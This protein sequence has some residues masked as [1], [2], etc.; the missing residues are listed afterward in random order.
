M[1][2]RVQ[3]PD[4]RWIYVPDLDPYLEQISYG[5]SPI[6][7][8]PWGMEE[9]EEEDEGTLAGSAWE[10]IKSIPS[11]VADIFLSG[12]QAAV[13]VATPFADLPVEKRL[14]QQASKRARERD[15]AYQ[16][17]FLPAVGTGLGQVAGLSALSRLPGGWYAAM[18]AGIGMGISDQTRR[19]ADYE[20]RT[21]TDVP[22]YKE[23]AAHMMGALIGLTEVIPVK[24]GIFPTSVSKMMDRM[25]SGF[26]PNS[27]RRVSQLEAKYGFRDIATTALMEATQEASANWLQSVSARGLYD[28]DAMKDLARSMAED[29]KVGG[30]VGGLVKL[31]QH[32]ILRSKIRGGSSDRNANAEVM[33]ARYRHDQIIKDVSSNI[34]GI[35]EEMSPVLSDLGIGRGLATDIIRLMGGEFSAIPTGLDHVLSSGE[36]SRFQVRGLIKEF[37][38][39]NESAKSQL[40]RLIEYHSNAGNDTEVERYIK[41]R[42][43]IDK[44]ATARINNLAKNLPGL[45]GGLGDMGG[46]TGNMQYE[47]A[48]EAAIDADAVESMMDVHEARKKQKE[49][50]KK[51]SFLTA[52]RSL[53]GGSYKLS[54]LFHMAESLGTHRGPG[55]EKVH[56]ESLADDTQTIPDIELASS[57]RSNFDI[58]SL[59]EMLFA[60]R[61][62]HEEASSDQQYVDKS[63]VMDG[64]RFGDSVR[65]TLGSTQRTDARRALYDLDVK[66]E[67]VE[68]NNDALYKKHIFTRELSEI[69]RKKKYDSDEEWTQHRDETQSYISRQSQQNNAEI[70]RINREKSIIYLRLLSDRLQSARTYFA[71]NI[72]AKQKAAQRVLGSPNTDR[73]DLWLDKTINTVIYSEHNGQR[74]KDLASEKAREFEEGLAA[75]TDVPDA[76]KEAA[77]AAFISENTR[78]FVQLPR[79]ISAT[80][81]TKIAS[82][83]VEDS[84]ESEDVLE[85]AF[86]KRALADI[87]VWR[88]DDELYDVDPY[89][90]PIVKKTR[91]VV[92]E[93]EKKLERPLTDESGKV[94]PK[95]MHKEDISVNDIEKL[96]ASKNIYLR[97]EIRIGS[98]LAKETGTGVESRPFKKLLEDMTGALSWENA[99]YGQRL[100]MYS[101][102]LQLPA[103][104]KSRSSPEER[105]YLL[106][107]G[108]IEGVFEEADYRPLFLPDFYH[109]PSIDSHINFMTDRV[110]GATIEG[111][112]EFPSL[113]IGTLKKQTQAALGDK[114]NNKAYYESLA[115]L[116]ETGAFNRTAEPAPARVST[117]DKDLL[118]EADRLEGEA[119][120]LEYGEGLI[121]SI[122]DARLWR[123]EDMTEVELLE[124]EREGYDVLRRE[125]RWLRPHPR[126]ATRGFFNIPTRLGVTLTPR[127]EEALRAEMGPDRDPNK[128]VELDEL[129]AEDQE[130]LDANRRER[131][132]AE[133]FNDEATRAE[134]LEQAQQ[135]LENL[136]EEEKLELLEG[137]GRHQ[138]KEPGDAERLG[139]Q[140]I[141]VLGNNEL[142]HLLEHVGDIPHRISPRGTWVDHRST[143]EKINKALNLLMKSYG[144]PVEVW[145]AGYE[146]PEY[147]QWVQSGSG[148]AKDLEEHLSGVGIGSDLKS[149]EVLEEAAELRRQYAEAHRQIPVY[150]QVQRL[151]T[152]APIALAEGRYG[153]AI[154]A[155]NQLR[156]ILEAEGGWDAP[157]EFSPEAEAFVPLTPEEFEVEVEKRFVES[158]ANEAARDQ[159][160]QEAQAIAD[161][162]D[163]PI[164]RSLA[165]QLV[166]PPLYPEGHTKAG[167]MKVAAWVPDWYTSRTPEAADRRRA[168]A[169]PELRKILNTGTMDPDF[170]ILGR[171][172][173]TMSPVTGNRVGESEAPRIA[174]V[175]STDAGKGG[176]SWQIIWKTK[177][178]STHPD[179]IVIARLEFHKNGKPNQV[180]Y[181]KGRVVGAR[182]PGRGGARQA[183]EVKTLVGRKHV[184][185][186]LDPITGQY[187]SGMTVTTSFKGRRGVT[188]DAEDILSGAA[189]ARE[190]PR[191][192]PIEREAAIP[193]E[194]LLRREKEKKDFAVIRTLARER[195]AARREVRGVQAHEQRVEAHNK[196]EEAKI[197][198][199][200]QRRKETER[201]PSALSKNR[202]RFNVNFEPTEPAAGELE[203]TEPGDDTR[204]R[205]EKMWIN[206]TN[207]GLVHRLLSDPRWKNQ[208]DDMLD[209]YNERRPGAQLNREEFIKQYTA[210]VTS[211]T[212][213][214]DLSDLGILETIQGAVA[215]PGGLAPTDNILDLGS[216]AGKNLVRALMKSGA[217]PSSLQ[218]NV[219]AVRRRFVDTMKT[220]FETL[221]GKVVEL[222]QA[223]RLPDNIQR[224]YVDDI[225]GLFQFM[226]EVAIRG[227]DMNADLPALYDRPGNRIIINLA[228]IDPNDM[229]SAQEVVK[230]A[231]FHEGL[232]ALIIRDHLTE[233]ELNVLYGFVRDKK[234]IVP[235]EIDEEAYNAQL[236]WFERSVVAHKDSELAEADIEKEAIISLLENL[237]QHPDLYVEGKK[238]RTITKGVRGF[239]EGFVDAA[240]DS[241][242]VDV[243]R[244]LGRIERG[245]VSERTA[246][247]LGDT[248]YT[249]DSIVR[250]ND[251][252]RYANPED[253]RKLKAAIVLRDAAPSD[254]MREIEQAKI[255][256]ISDKIVANRG[257]IRESAPPPPDAVQAIENQRQAIEHY[258]ATF[259]GEVPLLSLDQKNRDS[260]AYKLALDTFME[261]RGKDPRY[262][263]KMPEPYQKFFNKMSP[264]S[265]NLLDLVA[266][267]EKAGVVTPL[268][269]D[270]TRKSLEEGGILS[271]DYVRRPWWKGGGI[272]GDLSEADTETLKDQPTTGDNIKDTVENLKGSVDGLRYLY[273][274]RRQYIV[275]QT[276]K[277]I[278]AQ[279]RAQLDA[280]TSALVMWRN[281]DNALNWLPSLMLRGPL[282]Y[283]GTTVGSGRF[284]NAPIYDNDLQ[285]KYGGDGR[286][287]GLNDIIAPIIDAGSQQAALTYGL[288]KRVRWTRDRLE[289][290]QSATAGVDLENLNP[291]TR[292]KLKLFQESYEDIK[293]AVRKLTE[294]QMDDIVQEIET[295]ESNKIIIEFW[296]RYDAYDN[297]MIKMS[298]NTGMIT[299]EVRDEW[300][301]M[302]YAP[303]YRETMENED[304]P[305]GSQEQIAKRR[306]NV[307]EKALTESMK[308]IT[309]KLADSIITNTQALV[310]D[311]MMNTAVSRTVRDAVA[312]GEARK[313]NISAV[314]ASL[315]DRVVRVMEHGVPTYYQLDDA[316]V[317][318]SAMLLGFNPKRQLQ[319]LFGEHKLGKFMQTALTKSSSWLRDA[320][321]RTPPFA[322]KN[323]FRDSWNAMSL[324]GG[325][326][327]LILKAF[328]NAINPDSLRRADELGLSIGIDFVAEPGEYGNRM[329]SELKKANLDWKN[330]LNAFSIFWNFSGRIAKQSEVATRLAVYD[331]I[332]AMTGDKALA[333]HYAIEIMNYGRR[334][335]SPVLSTYMATVPF[336][337]GR[338]EGLDVTY[339]GLRGKKGSSDIPGVYGYGLTTGEYEGLPF[340]KKTRAKVVSRGL[341]LTAAT[342]VLYLLMRDDEEWQDLRDETRSDNWVLPLSDH[343]WIKIPIPFEIGVIFKV[344]PEKMFEAITEADV[345]VGDVGEEAWRQLRTSLSMG[346]PQLFTPVVNAMRNY[347]TFRKDGIVDSWMEDTLSPNEQRN[348]Y[349]SNVA[350]GVADLANSVPL[351]NKLDFL[352]S[353]MKVEYMMRQY[354]GT[355]GSYVVT[356]ADRIAR[357]G[358]LPDIP[359]D[360]YM[361]L[362][363]AES[364]I[365]TNKDFDW[366]S[367]I[368]GEGI[369]NV[370]LLGDLLTD[371]RTRQGSQQAFFEMIEDLDIVL[372]TLSSI[373]DR[374]YLKGFEYRKKHLDIL[375]HQR[376]L[377]FMQNQLK[378]WRERRDHF[379]KIPLESM[380]TDE[381]REYYQRLLESR[382][383]I[384]ASVND[385]MAS[386]R[387]E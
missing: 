236:T 331:R 30:A 103:H 352:T 227:E 208:I 144:M 116:I 118:D 180:T 64:F 363:E 264:L 346:G 151:A 50:S 96:L 86:E 190:Q 58:A 75:E 296:D 245:E 237:T 65:G 356:V 204:A 243:M 295:K 59:G 23:S 78:R 150:N 76:E 35:S 250:S 199:R 383:S 102:L 366:K 152:A 306:K 300:L 313:I 359:F 256:D 349:T 325:G 177:K 357:T 38:A 338:L 271:G 85:D 292:R 252:L 25:R 268:D 379:S 314:A 92:A 193:E 339:R 334:G 282:S 73:F 147:Q 80:Q 97:D 184:I 345:D 156:D 159:T 202:V 11:G 235:K 170:P 215:M 145:E 124:L 322:T 172:L 273:L 327:E 212:P 294:A 323:V 137:T 119:D 244:I 266:D 37:T 128:R 95:K 196:R 129:I 240:K 74:M 265:P 91:K 136:T 304:F 173:L 53:M 29:F 376:Q 108:T 175:I 378:Q 181:S 60:S 269:G 155:L 217:L 154:S 40:D 254:Q 93:L 146:S 342:G 90:I 305:I 120:P 270:V 101:R 226:G 7:G 83:F 191:R 77:R 17:A 123:Q 337:N 84:K 289:S 134:Q 317:A 308:P 4:G 187:R 55:S 351:V 354:L 148:F 214:Q 261:M 302:P 287:Q 348:R 48:K 24:F 68:K 377:R 249:N 279:N 89:G 303:F 206:E 8:L 125:A 158:K 70:S 276:D 182:G 28:P 161:E 69:D 107:R 198:S 33:R 81:V 162:G 219:H 183:T 262:A 110:M 328:G 307:V 329:R 72:S 372:A 233:E 140:H 39:R 127:I 201:A 362:A 54:G 126:F 298:Y 178:S 218:D 375:R 336:M 43:A 22:W 285:E 259:S 105:R 203:I 321:T 71:G 367:L 12:A 220:R 131:L 6:P 100:L 257:I 104:Y 189:E 316:Q 330:P 49:Y 320:V 61:G 194:V 42:V 47:E 373:T 15:P 186:P 280:E 368:G 82:L 263:Y 130:T 62:K 299:R 310:R 27:L 169:N 371:P 9:E 67:A 355:M 290:I 281:S 10:G 13:G 324:T 113:S 286:V 20:Q 229:V 1:P 228:A 232:H 200:E 380:S 36:I 138:R 45:E 197:L 238:T 386:I 188:R 291:E 165:G 311:A 340:W 34:T 139:Q 274:D 31:A 335:A 332:L 106:D 333:V 171:I 318:M 87:A 272:E 26:S 66:L 16:D 99:T 361:N 18:G 278:A 166:R 319:K 56:L 174:Y 381:G 51:P 94:A 195:A 79:D 277:L 326:P 192:D 98:L 301:S 374:D 239:L 258:R 3:L 358:I 176:T 353:P 297:H 88:A 57:D 111:H 288:I 141:E 230:Q 341:A 142:S 344:I 114:F 157:F 112:L 133:L 213:L 246:G 222:L 221:D 225:D 121:G 223:M 347:D 14:R 267:V 385:L 179:G 234:N 251:L 275:K 207:P 5:S 167:Q 260:E 248:E 44:M 382:Q 216:P 205:D 309:S 132:K 2:R 370:P 117:V 19:I 284:E 242:I 312:L 163:Q 211:V 32:Q 350:R 122:E 115:R 109:N 283:L 21:G 185:G 360:P 364:V 241:D 369:A 168:R 210:L 46:L 160:A 209:N 253:I 365:G 387:Q 231:A 143:I 164:D 255:D 52:I 149:P 224:Q 247:F 135:K 384:L 41:A 343:A 63:D 153:D 315:D 293:V